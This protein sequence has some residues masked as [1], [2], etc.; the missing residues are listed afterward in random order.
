MK[1]IKLSLKAYPRNNRQVKLTNYDKDNTFLLSSASP[2][3]VSYTDKSFELSDYLDEYVILKPK[4]LGFQDAISITIKIDEVENNAVM[5]S[6]GY[7]TLII[8]K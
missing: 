7:T 3:D 5:E 6:R 8:M 1:Q 4:N 2:V